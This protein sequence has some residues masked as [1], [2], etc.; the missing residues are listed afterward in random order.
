MEVRG[1]DIHATNADGKTAVELAHCRDHV[2]I[3]DDLVDKYGTCILRDAD[4]L[5]RYLSSTSD[6]SEEE[7]YYYYYDDEE[8]E[9]DLLEED[10]DYYEEEEHEDYDEEEEEFLEEEEEE[11]H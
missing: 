8:E 4:L 9:E 10:E 2:D 6:D 11:F 7:D 5:Q 1:L 3:V